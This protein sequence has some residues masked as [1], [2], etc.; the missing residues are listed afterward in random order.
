M[1]YSKKEADRN[2]REHLL[3]PPV[4]E[5]RAMS[6]RSCTCHPDNRTVPCMQRYAASEC[7]AAWA[8]ARITE[9]EAV[10]ARVMS[11]ASL[12]LRLLAGADWMRKGVE[13]VPEP[14]LLEEAAARIAELEATLASVQ[15]YAKEMVLAEREA[16]AHIAEMFAAGAV[17]AAAIRARPTP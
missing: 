3:L 8:A 12:N 15:I 1:N 4:K 10:E 5:A 16:C 11:E 17:P 14:K 7:Q 6:D 9:L 13:S 2:H